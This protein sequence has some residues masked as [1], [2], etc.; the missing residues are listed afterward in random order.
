MT[1]PVRSM[2]TSMHSAG[3]GIGSAALAVGDG[4]GGAV[5]SVGN[6][7]GGVATGIGGVATGLGGVAT[8]LGN[9]ATG[10]GSGIG[11]VATGIGGL[12][13]DFAHDTDSGEL[14]PRNLF[15]PTK[16]VRRPQDEEDERKRRKQDKF[17]D[18][19]FGR[20]A[21]SE[22]FER[23]TIGVI[24][25][26]AIE[27]GWDAD[28][29]ARFHKP[30]NLYQGPV[31]FIITGVFF[32]VYF[33]LEIVIRFIG[34]RRRRSCWKD[35]WFVFD[36]TLV[37]FM[38]TETV[39]LPMLG[40]GGPLGQLSVL[41][42][43]RL[44][45]II[46]VAK[47][48]R[49]FPQLLMIVRGINAAM[50]AVSW[51]ALL[52]VIVT[53][54]WA[55]MFTNQFHQGRR[56]DAEVEGIQIEVFFGSMGKS[57]LSLLVMGTILDD[58]TACTDSIR[59]TGNMGMLILFLVYVLLNSFTMMNMLVGILV[60]VVG[61]TAES[62]RMVTMEGAVRDAIMTIFVQMDADG[63]GRISRDEFL[64]M[65]ADPK[66]MKALQELD[67]HEKQ[68]DHYVDLLFHPETERERGEPTTLS[69]EELLDCILRLR[70]G[71]EISSLDF[72]SFRQAT[73]TAQTSIKERLERIEKL[74]AR[75]TGLSP[76][77]DS[78]KSACPLAVEPAAAT[79]SNGG[80]ET[81]A[82][83]AAPVQPSAEI[84][85]EVKPKITA[86]MLADLELTSSADLLAE[87]QRRLGLTSFEESG[88]PMYMMD[89][90]LQNTMK[91]STTFQMLGVPEPDPEW[92]TKEVRR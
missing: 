11:G 82:E 76:A 29:S 75:V 60:E 28:Y 69:F 14:P 55:V 2:K 44:V 54:T 84:F 49:A 5:H 51:T 56:S 43:L 73:T 45:R 52:L 67:I 87:L 1:N 35:G 59:D 89:E 27:I 86:S 39:V 68:F 57:M 72:A 32:C 6:G 65:K 33:T 16:E 30:D 64:E 20:I 42:L 36:T 62:E 17:S 85:L 80:I 78:E 81:L 25:L 63:S 48:M 66:V 41:R 26:N 23:A 77:L 4:I 24:M 22:Y 88:V 12:L 58:V 47:L 74:L 8:G 91:A 50:R 90:E 71:A 18:T 79:A 10:L 38:I 53:L 40:T 15:G 34:F 46:R 37:T 92:S 31:G 13:G 7:I 9:A 83:A 19:F 70:P 3:T 21:K 61:N